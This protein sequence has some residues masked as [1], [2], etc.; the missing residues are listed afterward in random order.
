MV[1]TNT[2]QSVQPYSVV[3]RRPSLILP[4]AC[5]IPGVQAKGPQYNLDM[6]MER[7][8]FGDFAIEIQVHLP[9][10]GPMGIFTR[11]PSFTIDESNPNRVRRN[12][13]P[14]L[15]TT[16]NSIRAAVGSKIDI[17][18]LHLISNCSI[19]RAEMKVSNCIESETEDFTTFHP[20]IKQGSVTVDL[21]PVIIEGYCLKEN[22]AVYKTVQKK[23]ELYLGQL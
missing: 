11:I 13:K 20:I 19:G 16:D 5:R 3:R 10:E 7:E 14:S 4:L 8:V 21:F 2:L 22:R 17:L 12:A 18:Y 9:G 15:Q 1:Y 6:P 23:S